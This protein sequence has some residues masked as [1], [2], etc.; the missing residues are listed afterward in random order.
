M[1][2]TDEIEID[3]D[4]RID[5]LTGEPEEVVLARGGCHVRID[6]LNGLEDYFEKR[7]NK[8]TAE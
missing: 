1:R 5:V 7:F 8:F 3:P 4:A 2:K 6:S